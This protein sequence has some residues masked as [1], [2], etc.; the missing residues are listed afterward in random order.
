MKVR[1]DVQGSPAKGFYAEIR[2]LRSDSLKG[3]CGHETT[4][5]HPS[6]GAANNCGETVAREKGWVVYEL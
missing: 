3:L 5:R 2:A 4:N 6:P 1:I